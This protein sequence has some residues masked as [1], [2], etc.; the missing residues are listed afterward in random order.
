MMNQDPNKQDDGFEPQYHPEQYGH[1]QHM[2]S[3]IDDLGKINFNSIKDILIL[4][5]K[6]LERRILWDL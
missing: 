6:M 1:L 2:H 5:P 4:Q 3:N